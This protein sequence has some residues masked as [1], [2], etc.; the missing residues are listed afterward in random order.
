LAPIV[1]TG[2]GT[3]WFI[4]IP[5]HKVYAAQQDEY[6]EK[7]CEP[8]SIYRYGQC[9]SHPGVE[10]EAKWH[11]FM[12]RESD[13]ESE[14]DGMYE[15]Q[16]EQSEAVEEEEG[17]YELSEDE[18]E[19]SEVEEEE[20]SGIFEDESEQSKVEEEED[21]P[22]IS[23]VQSEQSDSEEE[24]DGIGMSQSQ[25]VQQAI[26]PPPP[27]PQPSM[28]NPP[29][30]QPAPNPYQHLRDRVRNGRGLPCD[31]CARLRK[32]CS[33]KMTPGGPP[34]CDRCQNKNILC[35]W[36]TVGSGRRDNRSGN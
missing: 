33:R 34:R 27:P 22:G 23:P 36:N 10:Y 4:Q 5:K 6:V 18:V 24:K 2:N 14:A 32:P 19:Q 26:A 9:P 17:G 13:S 16:A 31:E 15:I 28:S 20:E 35:A 1:P 12:K 3:S 29:P 25:N 11:T 8:A 7:A 21:G 30:V